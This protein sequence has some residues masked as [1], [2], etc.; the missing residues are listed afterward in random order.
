MTPNIHGHYT[1]HGALQFCPVKLESGCEINPG[2]TIMP[3]TSYGNNCCLRPFAVTVKGQHCKANTEY[4]GNPCKLLKSSSHKVAILFGGQGSQYPGMLDH[5]VNC[6]EAVEL[7]EKAQHI[8]GIDILKL[9]SITSDAETMKNTDIAQP[10]VTVANLMAVEVM[11]KKDAIDVSRVIVCAGFSLGELS[12]L[13]FAGAISFEDTLK[14]VKIRADAMA[15]CEVGAMCNVRGIARTEIKG[16]SRRFNCSIANIIC[17]HD[18]AGEGKDARSLLAKNVYCIAGS[19]DNIDKLIEFV[20]DHNGDEERGSVSAK[21][22]RVSAA[23]HSHYMEDAKVKMAAALNLIDVKFPVNYLVYSNVTGRP[24]RSINEIRNVLPLQITSPVQWHNTIMDM[25][26]TEG[27]NKFI[28]CGPTDTLSK[29]VRLIVTDIADNQITAS[30]SY[31]MGV[32][33]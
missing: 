14:L 4:I 1:D 26:Q 31:L 5:L 7:L 11:R 10:I 17:D 29:T 2:V 33:G 32:G 12:A 20:N 30:D 21:R 8:L 16:L 13:C 3:L 25:T 6:T 24:Y 18:T 15:A 28:E 22:L 19:T 9:S 27:I 23:F